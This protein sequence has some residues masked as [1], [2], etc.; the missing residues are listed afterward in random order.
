MPV[1]KKISHSC[2]RFLLVVYGALFFSAQTSTTREYQ[3][4][5]AFVFNFTQFV[6][7]PAQSFSTPQSPAVIGIIGKDPFGN[8]LEETIAGETINKHPLVIQHFNTVEE[9]TNCHILFVN[10][11]DKAKLQSIIE[12]L[13]GKSILT[14]SDNNSFTKLGGMIR[15]YTRDDKINIQV[16]LEETKAGNLTISSKLLKLAEIVKTDKK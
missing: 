8:Y 16:N 6:E 3:I 5:A 10:I 15:L 14:I 7:W 12:K 4:K 1:L 13:K 2:S 11:N 9:V